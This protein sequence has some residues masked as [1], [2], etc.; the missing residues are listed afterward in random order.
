VVKRV[1]SFFFHLISAPQIT[2][3]HDQ[4]K[5]VLPAQAAGSSE[6]PSRPRLEIGPEL[7]NLYGQRGRSWIQQEFVDALVLSGVIRRENE[8]MVRTWLTNRKAREEREEK[9]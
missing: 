5:S 9:Q 4:Q 8:Q 6:N 1:S 7:E 3:E 2:N